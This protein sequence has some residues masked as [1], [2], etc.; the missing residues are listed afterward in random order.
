ML[1]E[2]LS[3]PVDRS[4]LWHRSKGTRTSRGI[5]VKGPWPSQKG[6]P[7][8]RRWFIGLSERASTDSKVGAHSGGRELGSHG[9]RFFKGGVGLSGWWKLAWFRVVISPYNCDG[10]KLLKGTKELG[11]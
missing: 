2:K 6:S 3:K 10:T 9:P 1:A 11:L 7:L 8:F 4:R 5:S